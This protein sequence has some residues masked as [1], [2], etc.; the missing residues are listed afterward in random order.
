MRKLSQYAE[1]SKQP[2]VIRDLAFVVDSG[3]EAEKLKKAIQATQKDKQGWLKSVILFDEFIPNEEGKG[4]KLNEKSLA[5]RLRF[6]AQ[7]RSLTDEDLEPI[8]ASM[9]ELAVENCQARLR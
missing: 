8:L 3:V 1:V 6:Q 7:D 4:L 2:V 9:I 5:F